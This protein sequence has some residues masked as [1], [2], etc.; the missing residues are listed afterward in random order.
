MDLQPLAALDSF[1]YR[2]RVGEVMSSPAVTVAPDATLGEAMRT[3]LERRVSSLLA[4]DADGRPSGI[5]T[6][7]DILRL[8]ARDGAAILA[9]P[10]ERLMS[11]PVRA[12][13]ADDFVYVALARMDRLGVRHLAVTDGEGR[14]VG[15]LSGRGLLKL[16]ANQALAIGDGI[17]VAQSAAELGAAAAALPALA[18]ALRADGVA[19]LAIAGLISGVMRDAT[20]R[21]AALAEAAL[22]ERLGPPPAAYAML[23][24]GSAGRGESLLATD[25]DN[26]L[27]HDGGEADDGWYAEL[28]KRAS[29]TLDAAGI[30]YCKGKV[31][32]SEPQWRRT[33]DG[34]RAQVS[35]WL[36]HSTPDDLLNVD[37]FFDFRPVHGDVAMGRK[38]RS[39]SLRMARRAKPFLKLLSVR[40][41]ELN[42][43]LGLFGGIRSVGGRVDLKR[44]GLLPLVSGAR[45][46][47]LAL[48]IE[49]P[50]TVERLRAAAEAGA[51]G[52]ADAENLADA[53]MTLLG[54]TLDQQLADIA[55]GVAPSSRVAVPRLS[56]RER[57]RLR[58][59]LQSVDGLK[60]AVRDVLTVEPR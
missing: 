35:A 41:D 24:L 32:A 60:V 43:P 20:A 37:I 49:A 30:P 2:H 25:Q 31:M 10:A 16:R 7:R 48:G 51:L 6:E 5:L 18:Q 44:G 38:L 27:A 56:L 47:G 22:T 52:A 57:A 29:D 15:A 19:P 45:I 40:L 28:G 36:R 58:A 23:V 50:G 39:D 55:A 33:R 4:A 1:P 12:V 59:A 3:M 54:A 42:A 46:M 13:A 8:V 34:W 17:A 11:R 21:A 14:L 26:A 53:Y 9:A